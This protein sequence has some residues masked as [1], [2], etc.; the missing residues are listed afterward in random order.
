ML[1]DDEMTSSPARFLDR[2]ARWKVSVLGL[3]TAFWHE[4]AVHLAATGT[5]ARCRFTFDHHRRRESARGTPSGNGHEAVAGR[6]QLFNCYGPT[7]GT[8]FATSWQ[9]PDGYCGRQVPIGS[10]IPNVATYLLG[11]DLRSVPIAVPGQL[12]IGGICLARAYHRRPALSASSFIPSPFSRRPGQRLYQTGDMARYLP[13]GAIEFLGRIDHQVKVRGFRVEV[14]EVES[15][16]S[17]L[18][19]VRKAVVLTTRPA[20]GSLRLTAYVLP[21]RPEDPTAD[22]VKLR[23]GLGQPVAGIYDP[24]CVCHGGV[25]SP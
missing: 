20:G 12:C 21:D 19:G 5:S 13:D 6:V 18:P 23:E 17:Q 1:R 8:V 4:I 10:P 22:G 14:G 3:P 16:L 9:L 7:E 25:V 2:V 11:P 15:V 24:R